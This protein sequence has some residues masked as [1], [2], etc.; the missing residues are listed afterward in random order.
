MAM[1]QDQLEVWI[2]QLL[3]DG[4]LDK[5]YQSKEWRKLSDTVMKEN[6]YECQECKKKGLHVKARSVHHVQ[7]V[8]KHPRLALS[9]SYEYK[10]A[11][12]ANLIP[13]CEN[14]HNKKHNKRPM[15]NKKK[16]VFVNE[17]RW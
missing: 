3:K 12:Y 5:F 1:T 16:K 15:P 13:L 10:G 6:N 7:W 2:K 8:W 11:T 17:E 4:R 14:C 9:K